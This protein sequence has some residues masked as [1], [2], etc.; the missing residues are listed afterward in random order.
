MTLSSDQL[1]LDLWTDW[2]ATDAPRRLAP[3]TIGEYK[4]QLVTFARWMET[5]LAVSFAPESIT[6]YRV[7]QCHDPKN[8][9]HSKC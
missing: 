4:R 6:S 2:L 1:F 5:T 8:L 9:G 7:E 3:A